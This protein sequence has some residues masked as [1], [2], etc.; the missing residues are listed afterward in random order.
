MIQPSTATLRA[1]RDRI[2][3]VLSAAAARY[4]TVLRC[5][6]VPRD[7][8]MDFQGG[9]QCVDVLGRARFTMVNEIRS[10]CGEGFEASKI[11]TSKLWNV[12]GCVANAVG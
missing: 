7:S 4:V 3:V 8:S 10:M 1:Q 12:I 2:R 9:V 5:S 6:T 11:R